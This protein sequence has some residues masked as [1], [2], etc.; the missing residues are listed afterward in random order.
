MAEDDLAD[1]L[2]STF[3]SLLQKRTGTLVSRLSKITD[4]ISDLSD[5]ISGDDKPKPPKP[6]A[7]SLPILQVQ[8]VN[9]DDKPIPV[10]V[11]GSLDD[12]DDDDTGKKDGKSKSP[13]KKKDDDD[14]DDKTL[15]HRERFQQIGRALKDAF[16]GVRAPLSKPVLPPAL[17]EGLGIS[18]RFKDYIEFPAQKAA[19]G[20]ALRA[21]WTPDLTPTLPPTGA[22]TFKIPPVSLLKGIEL[23]GIAVPKWLSPPPAGDAGDAGGASDDADEDGGK[24]EKKA[25]AKKK[26]RSSG[27]AFSVSGGINITIQAQSVEASTA[28]AT[29]RRIAQRIHKELRDITQSERFRAG[30]DTEE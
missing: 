20:D 27:A 22:A 28:D 5:Q 26:E 13:S 16:E 3:S 15:S 11:I 14:D 23:P 24:V 10:K 6:P 7:G 4:A 30:L 25:A 19:I 21:G 2:T 18:Q 12:D 9:A 29:G 8:I 17:T 1:R